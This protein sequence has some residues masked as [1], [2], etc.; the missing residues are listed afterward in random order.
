MDDNPLKTFFGVLGGFL[1]IGIVMAPGVVLAAWVTGPNPVPTW[2]GISGIVTM[3]VY[4]AGVFTVA[5][6]V[7]PW[8]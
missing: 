4:V 7:N 6:R 1:L 3:F 2:R 8:R 5:D